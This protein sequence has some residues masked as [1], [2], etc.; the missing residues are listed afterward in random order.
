MLSFLRDGG[1][2]LHLGTALSRVR[3]ALTGAFQRRG[4]FWQAVLRV[5]C[6]VLAEEGKGSASLPERV[7]ASGTSR[8]ETAPEPGDALT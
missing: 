6:G 2:A 7:T 8:I 4:I 5:G 3:T 1:A